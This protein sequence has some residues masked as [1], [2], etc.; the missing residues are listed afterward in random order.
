M[1]FLAWILGESRLGVWNNY[2]GFYKAGKSGDGDSSNVLA[3]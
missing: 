1:T 2:K 3:R